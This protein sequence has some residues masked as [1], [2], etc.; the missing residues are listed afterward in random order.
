MIAKNWIQ[1]ELRSGFGRR[2]TGCQIEDGDGKSGGTD[3]SQHSSRVR[4]LGRHQAY[5]RLLANEHVEP[6]KILDCHA[7]KSVAMAGAY[8]VVLC[9]QDATE[10]DFSSQPGIAGLGRLNYEA[11]Q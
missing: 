2:E 1:Q 11:R 4:G 8:P 3:D 9:L 10:L 6:L 5:Y 7:D